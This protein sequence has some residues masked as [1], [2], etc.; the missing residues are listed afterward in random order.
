M[1][2]D[3]LCRTAPTTQ[4][5]GRFVTR[6]EDPLDA[7]GAADARIL[8][9]RRALIRIALIAAETATRFAREGAETDPMTWMLAP[10]R[11]FDGRAPIDA[12][13]DRDACLRAIL[14]HGLSVGM[15]AD[16]DEID[17][18]ARDDADGD[19]A[20][21]MVDAD[22]GQSSPRLFTSFLVGAADAVT[23]QAFDAVIAGSRSE[24]EA[25]LRARHG[26][27]LADEMEIV[28]GFDPGR[29]LAEALV[30]PALADMLV[31]V[32]SDPG[33]PLA[34]GLSIAVQ[35]RFAA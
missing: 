6:Y 8:T 30:S 9:T 17:D 23:V 26:A 12:C 14:L 13:L 21:F 5:A 2:N 29:P 7:D 22:E 33:S 1:L 32:A 28:E 27:L 15:D 4:N 35:Q 16:P 31:Q 18:L 10:R 20:D 3:L 19:D 24:A 25:R 34:E 11:L